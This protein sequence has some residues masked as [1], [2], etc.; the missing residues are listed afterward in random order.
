MRIIN[1]HICTSTDDTKTI[2][3]LLLYF[4]FVLVLFK[5]ISD[6]WTVWNDDA[7]DAGRIPGNFYFKITRNEY[8]R[9]FRS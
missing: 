5:T 7:M 6:V 1:I 9:I 8:R 4:F 2:R 3:V